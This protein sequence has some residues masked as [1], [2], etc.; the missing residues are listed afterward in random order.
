MFFSAATEPGTRDSPNEDWVAISPTTAIVLDGVTVPKGF[1]IGCTHGTAWYVNH[2]GTRFLAAAADRDT[3]LR[4]AL[5]TAIGSV[6][7]LHR[8]VCD[9]D[10]VGAPSAAV[11][12]VRINERFVEYLVLADVTVLVKSAQELAV[13][14]DERVAGTVDDLA[15]KRDY[16]ADVMSRRERYR[17]KEGGYWVAASDPDAAEHAEVGQFPLG[18][19]QCAVMMSDGVSRLVSPFEQTDW[20]GLLALAQKAGPAAVIER[21]RKVE[22]GDREKIRWARFKVSDDATIALINN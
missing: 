19:F 10:Q 18:E 7:D 1:R 9:L 3:S 15:G 5:R 11:G 17:N 22:D 2:L 4:S 6:A 16:G 13:V 8:G 14:S 21:V 20:Q 12:A